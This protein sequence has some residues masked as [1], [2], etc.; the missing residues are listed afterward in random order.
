MSLKGVLLIYNLLLPFALILA[1]PGFV[2][3]MVRRGNYGRDFLQRFGIYRWDVGERLRENRET[4]RVLWVHAVSVGEVFI[5][6]KLIDAILSQDR[7]WKIVL[8][9]TTS[10]G[11]ALAERLYPEWGGSVTVMYNPID[12]PWA[13]GRALRKIRPRALVLVEA[14]IWPNLVCKA[15]AMGMPVV[16][17]N[18]RLSP[19]SESRFRRFAPL[20]RPL[21]ALLDA[22]LVQFE[23]DASRWSGLGVAPDR[24]R[25]LGS[26]K[27]DIETV[28][29]A[30]QVEVFRGLLRDVA[31]VERRPV[32]LA[33]S[34]HAGEEKLIGEVWRKLREEVPGLFLIVVPRH[35]ERAGGV[36]E[37]LKGL[38]LEPVL[39]ST[40]Q[41]DA[42]EGRDAVGGN[43]RCLV[44]DTTGELASWYCLADA[45]IIGKSFLSAGGQNPVEPIGAGK[46]V[47]V[48]P[49][50]E[51]FESIVRE[52]R[53][54]GGVVQVR[55]ADE[56]WTRL[57][58]YWRDPERG[59]EMAAAGQKVLAQ[60]RGASRRTVEQLLGRFRGR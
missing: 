27:F 34:T 50:M 33:G 10:T 51:N 9:T 47:F 53:E 4:G 45:V 31:G 14:E 24:I 13:S 26:I 58:E 55:D 44:V 3:K 35:F 48:G 39:R 59:R 12:L 21:F 60:H 5:A 6:R 7:T 42:R 46:P 43:E 52:L 18:A 40:L 17:V 54:A 1:L 32:L 15:K 25:W 29:D 38:G 56:L 20:V 23:E 8:S 19:R 16:L 57:A 2:V 36:V 41:E 11:H 30:G 22:V 28:G 49:R 37:D